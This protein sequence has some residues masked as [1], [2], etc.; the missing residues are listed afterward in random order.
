M[1]WWRLSTRAAFMP[2]LLSLF[3][4]DE[5]LRRPRFCSAFLMFA[6]I[7]IMGSIPGARAEIA[8]FGSGVVL[9]SVAYG[10]LTLL[11]FTGLSGSRNQRAL[12]AV[13]LVAAMGGL[14]EFVQSFLPY[15]MGTLTDWLVDCAASLVTAGLLWRFMPQPLQPGHT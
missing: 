1:L 2:S 6:A 11:L 14:D 7:L 5:R 9:H 13:L 15:R 4:L 12:R 8:Q 10:V 3:V